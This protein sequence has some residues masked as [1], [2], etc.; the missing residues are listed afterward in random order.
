VAQLVA[1]RS[2]K[3]AVAGSSPVAPANKAKKG[4]KVSE[5]TPTTVEGKNFFQRAINFLR[6]VIAE[7]KKVVWPTRFQ[8]FNYTVVV[9]VFV[10]IVALI[11]SAFDFL[12]TQVAIFIFG[13]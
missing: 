3:P 10:V 5:A 2:P 12:F 6:Q 4:I 7:L 9:L 8:L 1:H 13:S 11:I